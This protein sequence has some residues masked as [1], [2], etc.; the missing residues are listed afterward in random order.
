M[1]SLWGLGLTQNHKTVKQ[2]QTSPP[3]ATIIAGKTATATTLPIGQAV[4]GT[5]AWSEQLDL[6]LAQHNRALIQPY[7]SIHA[8]MSQEGGSV[9]FDSTPILPLLQHACKVCSTPFP[10]C[11]EQPPARLSHTP[12]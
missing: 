1:K 12:P 6:I 4:H 7:G 11:C 5:R 10:H 9:S 8:Q 2:M 3:A